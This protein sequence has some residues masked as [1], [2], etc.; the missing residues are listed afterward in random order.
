VFVR[1][2][3]AKTSKGTVRNDTGRFI[4]RSYRFR[5]IPA[6][7]FQS[8]YI[9]WTNL[10]CCNGWSFDK[11][12]LLTAVQEGK[13]LCA[14][15]TTTDENAFRAYFASLS[16]EYPYF[17]P[18]PTRNGPHTFY[19]IEVTRQ[20]SIADY[21]DISAARETYSAL[22]IDFLDFKIISEYATKPMIQLLD[23]TVDFNY[24]NPKGN[25]QLAVTGLLLGYPLE[26]TAALLL[27]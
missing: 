5:N 21:I 13:K 16:D 12:Y 17:C 3:T 4:H 1:S 10:N 18:P 23:G 19:H 7:L 22:G 15:I 25:E 6:D 11:S 2:D 8:P 24:A 26:S 14:G 27:E 9:S 20:G